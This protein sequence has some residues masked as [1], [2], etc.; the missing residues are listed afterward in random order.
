MD[1][2]LY[3][4]ELFDASRTIYPLFSDYISLIFDNPTIGEVNLKLFEL[5]L[6]L[7]N[8]YNPS[9]RLLQFEISSINYGTSEIVPISI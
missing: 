7:A 9:T 6:L 4:V 5:K 8:C 3:M 2:G 1:I